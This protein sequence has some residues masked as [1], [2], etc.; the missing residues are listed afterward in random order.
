MSSILSEFVENYPGSLSHALDELHDP[1]IEPSRKISTQLV[2]IK[3][4]GFQ[5]Y[6][7]LDFELLERDFSGILTT[8]LSITEEPQE[9]RDL[10]ASELTDMLLNQIDRKGTTIEVD[11]LSSRPEI[12]RLAPRILELRKREIENLC[13]P[14]SEQGVDLRPLWLTAYG[15][16][17][18]QALQVKT[19]FVDI[20]DPTYCDIDTVFSDLGYSLKT[21]D[22]SREAVTQ[23]S[24]SMEDY[25]MT[26]LA[27]SP[28]SY[29]DRIRHII[30][31]NPNIAPEEIARLVKVP[32]GQV[33]RL[34]KKLKG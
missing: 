13:L 27:M 7:L 16:Q 22:N 23:I 31:S 8:I 15:L 30:Q 19:R 17:S 12:I 1:Y 4:L 34:W 6:G 11:V 32:I 10:Y 5:D 24:V 9:F 18:L 28:V 26:E 2:I 21:G 14:L 29:E 25:I 20:R 33:R 3:S